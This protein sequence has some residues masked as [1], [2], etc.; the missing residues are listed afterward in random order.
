MELKK[1]SLEWTGIVPG[2][3]LDYYTPGV[4]THVQ[5]FPLIFDVVHNVASIPGDG[6]MTQTFTHTTDIGK[7][8]VAALSLDKWE[9]RYF[10]KGDAL[11]WNQ[12]VALAERVK[13]VKFD[14]TY[15][16]AE[17]IAQGEV[18]LIWGHGATLKNMGLDEQLIKKMM[19][20]LAKIQLEGGGNFGPGSYLNEIFPEIKPLKVEE[21]LIRSFQK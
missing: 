21:G 7:Y 4:P 9:Q 17:R 13:G 6:E 5:R 2:I 18:T 12:L 8:T 11:T 15:D 16:S 1:T 3:F 10:I 20:T 14:V 19:L